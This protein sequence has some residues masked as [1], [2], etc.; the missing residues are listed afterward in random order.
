M[1]RIGT[2]TESKLVVASCWTTWSGDVGVHE[3]GF[4][5]QWLQ[6][7]FWNDE[8]VLKWVMVAQICKYTGNH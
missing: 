6:V 8:N 7:C 5:C 3:D 4:D 2:E 1:F